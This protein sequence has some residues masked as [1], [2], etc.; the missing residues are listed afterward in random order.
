[1]K[2]WLKFLTRQYREPLFIAAMTREIDIYTREASNFIKAILGWAT[3]K[4]LLQIY[5][6]KGGWEGWAQVE[7]TVAFQG[8]LGGS[9]DREVEVYADGERADILNT[10]N[11]KKTI[12]ELKC[13]STYQDM[14]QLDRF[15]NAFIS[16]LIKVDYTPR[17]GAYQ[18]AVR[19]VLGIGVTGTAVET[20][21]ETF[22][23]PA[24]AYHVRTFWTQ[25]PNNGPIV[26]Y[27]LFDDS[28]T[29]DSWLVS[30]T[31]QM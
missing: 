23:N 16:D 27:A 9:N 4:P 17:D 12:F 29:S 19:V 7:L 26:F 20:A 21:I 6:Q 11:N 2:T 18:N 31:G 5:S 28:G 30:S 13:Q 14:I 3:S 25:A 10:A 8:W 1:M 22:S 15:A 24:F